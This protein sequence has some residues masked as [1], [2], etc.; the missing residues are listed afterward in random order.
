VENPCDHGVCLV[1]ELSKCLLLVDSTKDHLVLALLADIVDTWSVHVISRS[2]RRHFD[3]PIC[4]ALGGNEF[5]IQFRLG[6]R[7]SERLDLGWVISKSSI[8]IEIFGL[9]NVMLFCLQQSLLIFAVEV[10]LLLHVKGW[11]SLVL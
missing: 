2:H 1:D 8:Y 11:S 4:D 3:P 6:V 5:F 10:D 7:L 9:H